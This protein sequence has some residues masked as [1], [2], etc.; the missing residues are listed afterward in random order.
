MVK[1]FQI[2]NLKNKDNITE[3][4]LWFDSAD[5]NAQF[6]A[7]IGFLVQFAMLSTFTNGLFQ[8][9]G[10]AQFQLTAANWNVSFPP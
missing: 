7:W 8:P 9:D 5:G 10:N 6:S 1:K 4:L 2:W 3:L